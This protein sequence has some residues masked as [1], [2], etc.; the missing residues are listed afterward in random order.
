MSLKHLL[1]TKLEFESELKEITID[2]K[3]GSIL[4]VGGD[5]SQKYN[6]AKYRASGLNNSEVK[7]D[8]FRFSSLFNKVSQSRKPRQL[9]RISNLELMVELSSWWNMTLKDAVMEFT[10]GDLQRLLVENLDSRD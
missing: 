1:G 10:N 6:V 5:K 8:R 7:I 3:H 2:Y 9:T 4:G